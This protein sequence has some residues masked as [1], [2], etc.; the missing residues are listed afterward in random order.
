MPIRDENKSSK[1][2][3][4]SFSYS[5]KY[6]ELQGGLDALT[7]APLKPQRM[8]FL[9]KHF[10]VPKILHSLIF[11][12]G[13]TRRSKAF[14]VMTRGAVRSWFKRP[15]DTRCQPECFLLGATPRHPNWTVAITYGNVTLV[16]MLK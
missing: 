16:V 8:V 13:N 3:G 2:L 14:D 7:E 10:L 11:A 12:G 6:L 15:R 4:I 5:K 1:R 9:L